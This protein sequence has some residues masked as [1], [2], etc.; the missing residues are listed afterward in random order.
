MIR[1][2][3]LV[4]VL[5]L[6]SSSELELKGDKSTISFTGA[7]ATCTIDKHRCMT[8]ST[9]EARIAALEV[10]LGALEKLVSGSKD[11]LCLGNECITS[12]GELN[13]PAQLGARG[14]PNKAP[15]AL[16]V[17]PDNMFMSGGSKVRITGKNFRN[18]HTAVWFGAA[19]AT[20]VRVLSDTIVECRAPAA[21]QRR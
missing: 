15:W 12:W 1:T 11:K 13:P 17:T 8:L 18:G 3:L 6:A 7:T 16:T 20:E 10:K 5:G 21:W 2:A 4:A 9:S 19:K 14:A